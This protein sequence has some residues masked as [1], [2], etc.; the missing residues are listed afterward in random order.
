ML[1]FI[2]LKKPKLSKVLAVKK[3]SYFLNFLQLAL[4]TGLAEP[5]FGTPHKTIATRYAG[6]KK[7][8]RKPGFSIN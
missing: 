3:N 8:G 7:T 6:I 1:F 2:D 5:C 4:S